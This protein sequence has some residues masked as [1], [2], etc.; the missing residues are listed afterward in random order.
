ML[1]NTS[2]IPAARSH[3]QK[4]YD[5][6]YDFSYDSISSQPTRALS[7]GLSGQSGATLRLD[8]TLHLLHPGA[9]RACLPHRWGWYRT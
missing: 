8:N 3:L 7:R 6:T 2:G 9:S 5:K 1:R 4:A